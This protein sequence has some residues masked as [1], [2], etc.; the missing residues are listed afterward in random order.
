MT[1]IDLKNHPNVG[2]KILY[3]P[4]IMADTDSETQGEIKMYEP[5]GFIFK[6]DMLSIDEVEHWI[7]A[8]ECEFL[9]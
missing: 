3:K 6:M 9:E 7:P 8:H 4:V 5:A 1:Q 2:K